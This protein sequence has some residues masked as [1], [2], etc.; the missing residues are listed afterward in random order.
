MIEE[1]KIYIDRLKD[2]NVQ[3]VEGAFDP[4]LLEIEETDLQFHHPVSVQAEAY[5]TDDHLVIRL[6]ASTAATIPCAICNEPTT[7][8][9]SCIDSYFTEDLEE[10]KGAVYDFGLA[11]RE[12]LLIEVPHT[13]ECNEGHCPARKSLEHYF[14]PE[15]KDELPTQSPFNDVDLDQ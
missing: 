8:Q 4:A 12:N 6:S 10:I 9:V 14:R 5:T 7:A 15:D 11:L 1:F 13:I 3:K 2:G